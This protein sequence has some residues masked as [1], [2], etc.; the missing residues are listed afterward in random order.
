MKC[1]V[2]AGGSGDRLWPL[3]RKNYPK[4]FIHIKENRSLFQETIARNIPFCEEFYIITSNR[5]ANIVEG[6]LQVFQGLRYRCFYE[7]EGKKTAPAVA[8]ACLCDNR[9]EDYLVV[10]TD[11]MIEGGDYKGAIAKGREYIPQ[12]KIVC[13][14]I[15][16]W[17]FEPGYGYFRQVEERTEFRH[18][19]MT[20]EIPAGEKWYYDTGI[21]L[22][23]GGDF[24]HELSRKSPALYAQIRECVD[25]LDTYGR[26]VLVPGRLVEEL[27]P[28]SIGRAVTS[29]S[30]KVLLLQADFNWKRIMTL[31]S[32]DQYY[33]GE[34]SGR[35]I[36]NACENVSVMNEAA[37][38]LVVANGLED[39]I[40]VNTADAVYVSRKSE[41]DQIKSIIRENYEKQQSYFDEGTV[42]YTPWGIK[43]TIHY[44]DSC[45]VKKI[46]IFPG[47]ELSR[48]VH[49]LRTEHWSVISGVATIQLDEQMGEYG[50]GESIS[51]PMGTPHQIA[52]RGTED[53]VVIEVS[54]G[55]L[56]YGHGNDLT[57]LAG[58]SIVKT[59]C[60]E[61]VRMEPAF[62]DN[63]WG[64]TRLRDVYGKK[65]D[66]D[67]VAESWELSTHKAGQSIVATGKN[68]GLMLGEYINRFG[69]GILGWKC[70]PYERFPLL[71]KFID[72]RE[73]LSIQVHP[74]DDY[75]LQKEDEYGKNE[76]WYVVDC[77]PESYL[78]CGFSRDTDEAEVRRR[79]EDGT[80]T[81]ILNKIPVKKGD[82]YFIENG[83]VHAIGPGVLI[84]EIQQSSNVTYRLYDYQRRDKYGELRELHIDKAMEV[85]NFHEKDMEAAKTME[86]K[87]FSIEKSV[88]DGEVSFNLDDSS[89]RA[90]VVLEGSGQVSC[91]EESLAYRPAD[92]FFV[93]AGKKTVV[94]HGCGTVL[95]VQV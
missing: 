14:G 79:I 62:K 63:L 46:T 65:C 74:G 49:K 66:Y 21:L 34:D 70:D 18:S 8:I 24:L 44:G 43:E 78:Y 35:V 37:H 25:Q 75:A 53:L 83:T 29:V 95:K 1:I 41:A 11:H 81:E 7:E 57:R 73:S 26:N 58:Q 10:S 88:F 27:E 39:V 92:C 71:I 86:C 6:Q 31:E 30:D 17:R 90:F 94:F 80:L 77:E 45:K 19:D 52:N 36:R 33:H 22:F 67:I 9:S 12:G 42:Y 76:L 64:G 32:L 87:Y 3:S 56:E 82:S 20:E 84:C 85:T 28:V 72:S 68:K 51:V 50:S 59:D 89:F 69:R 61:I 55:E 13:L 2:L 23:N 93:P 38:Q 16:A 54:V 5:Y 91:G 15:P 4:Q 60:D 48:H 47:K 40:I